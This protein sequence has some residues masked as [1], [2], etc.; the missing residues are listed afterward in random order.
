MSGNA[1]R[2][3]RTPERIA[4]YVRA[5]SR[6]MGERLDEPYELILNSDLT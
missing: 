3:L 4:D 1:L 2:Y 5:F 6:T